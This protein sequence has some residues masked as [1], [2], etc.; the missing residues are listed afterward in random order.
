MGRE[1]GRANRCP[2]LVRGPSWPCTEHE[3]PGG[4]VPPSTGQSDQ[5][6]SWLA[7]IHGSQFLAFHVEKRS[8]MA[9]TPLYDR[10][11]HVEHTR[12]T[13]QPPGSSTASVL[14]MATKRLL[15]DNA[16][17]GIAP[18][19][20]AWSIEMGQRSRTWRPPGAVSPSRKR[21]QETARSNRRES[22]VSVPVTSQWCA[23]EA[24][25]QAARTRWPPGTAEGDRKST[26]LNSSHT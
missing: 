8:V 11:T 18:P 23:Q 21:D 16:R 15:F 24:A 1:W 19:P 2:P 26:R 14:E 6:N 10:P 5:K 12:L 22:L 9:N 4:Q 13:R 17:R 25:D 20:C 3:G 7:W